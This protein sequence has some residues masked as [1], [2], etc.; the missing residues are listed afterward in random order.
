MRM[1]KNQYKQYD[2]HPHYAVG[3]IWKRRF[4]SENASSVFRPHYTSEKLKNVTITGHFGFVFA[5]SLGREFTIVGDLGAASQD[6][7]IVPLQLCPM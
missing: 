1:D 7:A 3:G 4:R 5:E 2:L 6:D